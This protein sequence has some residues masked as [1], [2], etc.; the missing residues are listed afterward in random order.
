PL[1]PAGQTARAFGLTGF[2]VVPRPLGPVPGAV[3][4][5][6]VVIVG[7]GA[8][9]R[10]LVMVG[11]TVEGAAPGPTVTVGPVATSVGVALLRAAFA[12]RAAPVAAIVRTRK[13]STGQIQSPGYHAKRRCHDDAS[14]PTTPRLVGSRAPHSRQ[15]SWS[16]SY[17]T[18]HFGQ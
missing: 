17:P 8:P 7:A 14:T 16:G 1:W 6:P 13:S 11:A 10:V 12:A 2:G 18:P 9:G 15:Y 5:G 3:G 4:S